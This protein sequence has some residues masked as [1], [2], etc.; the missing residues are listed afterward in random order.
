VK[1]HN[2]RVAALVVTGLSLLAVACTTAPEFDVVI[3]G[4][5]VIDG[6]GAEPRQADVGIK[7]DRITAIANLTQRSASNRIDATGRI[8]A[9]GFIDVM[10]HSGVNFVAAGLAEGQLRQGIT[11]QMLGNQSPAF[12][13]EAT[14]DQDA[15]RAAGIAFDW[16]GLTGYFGRLASRGSAINVG[17]LAPLSMAPRGNASSVEEAMQ[18]GAWGVIDDAHSTVGD[19][20]PVA[21]AVGRS[22]G[23]LMLPVESAIFSSDESLVAIGASAHRILISGVSRVAP[24]PPMAEFNGRIS[25]ATERDIAVYATVVPSTEPSAAS[26]IHDALRSGGVMVATDSEAHGAFARLLG[27]VVRDDRVMELREAVRRSTSLPA[28][29]F[30]LPQRGIIREHYFADLV[31]FDAGTIADR[32]TPDSANQY[33]DGIDYVLVNGVITLTPRGMT[34]ARPGYGLVR[35][36]SR[37]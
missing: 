33:P 22:D 9:P 36:R 11:T 7:G 13:T 10:S 4:G 25:R 5:S 32:P 17:T 23:V 3:S 26:S 35:N 24:G 30:K 21:A 12:W 15:L 8:V 29:V 19:L 2:A 14:A 20:T 27:Q 18:E 1:R 34:G 16:S 37:Q 6:T 28:T 31:V